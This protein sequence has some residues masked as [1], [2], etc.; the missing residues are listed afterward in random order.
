MRG[1][2]ILLAVFTMT[3]LNPGVA[4][5]QEAGQPP[6]TTFAELV[7]RGVLEEGK[8]VAITFRFEESTGYEEIDGE[9]VRLSDTA[10]VVRVDEVPEGRTNLNIR[11]MP[12]DEWE[13]EIPEHRVQRIIRGGD[14]MSRLAG[15]LIGG[16]VGMVG[17]GAMIG[18]CQ[19]ANE[20][21]SGCDLRSPAAVYLAVVG[22]STALGVALAGKSDP[23]TVYQSSTLPAQISSNLRWTLAPVVTKNQKGAFFTIRW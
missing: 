6:A 16:L 12:G 15:G 19:A 23:T 20:A 21:G 17:G 9:V 13:I 2:A 7:E 4:A 1:M 5:A 8:D 18:V 11:R 10:I 14:G 22:G 3:A